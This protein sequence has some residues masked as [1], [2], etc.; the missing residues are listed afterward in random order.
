MRTTLL[1]FAACHG[2]A[3][4]PPRP[5]PT[6]SCTDLACLSAHEGEV[7]ELAG[8]LSLPDDPKRKGHHLHHLVL[9]DG[10]RVVLDEPAP[11]AGLADGAQIKLHGRIFVKTIPERYGIIERTAEPYLLELALVP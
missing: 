2:S 6:A 9:A 4:Q 10:T 5:P 11:L 8:T 7:I 1:L 3:P